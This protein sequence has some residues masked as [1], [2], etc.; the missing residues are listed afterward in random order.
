M[1]DKFFDCLNCSSLSAGKRSRNPFKS[2]YRSGTDWKLKVATL[3]LL[4]V[5][6]C[7]C[8]CVCILCVL[9]QCNFHVRDNVNKMCT[10]AIT[11]STCVV[12]NWGVSTIPGWVGRQRQWKTR[13]LKNQEGDD[14]AQS[15]NKNGFE[16]Y[17]FVTNHNKILLKKNNY[18]ESTIFLLFYLFWSNLL[19]SKLY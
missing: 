15:W 11:I 12:A 16:N 7:V 1:F 6:V 19:C 2:P 10:F 13:F 5:C 3:M 8:V 9:H 14:A 17:R 18:C 4:C